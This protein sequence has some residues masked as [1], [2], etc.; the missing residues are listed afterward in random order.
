[1]FVWARSCS[2]CCGG[3]SKR[4]DLHFRNVQ[5]HK[6]CVM[7]CD[8]MRCSTVSASHRST[9]THLSAELVGTRDVGSSRASRVRRPNGPSDARRTPAVALISEVER[10]AFNKGDVRRPDA[11]RGSI[12]KLINF[13]ARASRLAAGWRECCSA[14]TQHTL[15]LPAEMR[16]P[17]RLADNS[18]VL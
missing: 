8:V 14:L 1:M 6:S 7:W 5:T 18:S 3:H 13:R 16:R 4:L 10:A 15:R 9:A 11:T 17:T 12:Y 2:S